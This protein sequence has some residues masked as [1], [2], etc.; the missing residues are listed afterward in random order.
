MS[1]TKKKQQLL[2]THVGVDLRNH[3]VAARAAVEAPALPVDH[4]RERAAV[5]AARELRRH[6]G[7]WGLGGCE[8]GGGQEGEGELEE[9]EHLVS[10]GVEGK[11]S[12]DLDEKSWLGSC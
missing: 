6:L 11:A 10:C 1:R 4:A 8:L 12:K 3:V 9:G 2:D 5:V 7:R